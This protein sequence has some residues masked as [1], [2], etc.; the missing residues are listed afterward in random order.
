MSTPS[1]NAHKDAHPKGHFCLP[2]V[3]ML[4]KSLLHRGVVDRLPP[5]VVCPL[6]LLM[7]TRRLGISG[8]VFPPQ[9]LVRGICNVILIVREQGMSI[10]SYCIK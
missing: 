8:F 2:Q 7:F 6:Q 1:V 3:S 9:V 4:T 10:Y 5:R